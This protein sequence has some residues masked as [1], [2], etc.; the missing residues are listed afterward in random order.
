[1]LSKELVDKL[2]Q[3]YFKGKSG[4]TSPIK[5][6][7]FE[8]SDFNILLF[9]NEEMNIPLLFVNNY[10]WFLRLNKKHI[11][12]KSEVF[13]DGTL[14]FN[15]FIDITCGANIFRSCEEYG[16]NRD[17]EKVFTKQKT[18]EAR[19][20]RT[21]ALSQINNTI[22]NGN[23]DLTTLAESMLFLEESYISARPDDCLYCNKELEE[24]PENIADYYKTHINKCL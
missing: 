10:S 8:L 23:L 16:F 1:L 24:N 12:E 19:S 6:I 18:R 15:F 2:H 11:Q 9:P 21:S 3:I 17:D 13:S 5:F 20:T 14:K 4:Y 7:E 22:Q